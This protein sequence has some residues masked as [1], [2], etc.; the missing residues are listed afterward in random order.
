M[1]KNENVFVD[2]MYEENLHSSQSWLKF[3]VL[4]GSIITDHSVNVSPCGQCVYNHVHTG[5]NMTLN[6]SLCLLFYVKQ[7]ETILNII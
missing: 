6:L 5:S 7:K 3:Q 2:Y 1:I 4:L